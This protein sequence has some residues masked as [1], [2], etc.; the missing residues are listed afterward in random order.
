LARILGSGED[1]KE[2]LDVLQAR[3]GA[4]VLNGNEDFTY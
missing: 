3:M 2:R 1:G 4:A